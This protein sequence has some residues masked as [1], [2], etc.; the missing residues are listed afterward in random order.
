MSKPLKYEMLSSEDKLCKYE[1]INIKDEDL[2]NYVY[3]ARRPYYRMRGKNI[4][5]EQ[6]KEIIR[7]TDNYFRGHLQPRSS[8]FDAE[9]LKIFKIDNDMILYLLEGKDY[10]GCLNFDS[11][12][13]D[14]HHFSSFYGWCHP[15]GTIGTS[16]ITQKYPTMKELVEE[17]TEKARAFPFLDLT[18]A[19]TEDNE[20]VIPTKFVNH[21]VNDILVKYRKVILLN[22]TQAIEKYT[23]YCRL[24]DHEPLEE[25][26]FT[27][28]QLNVIE[29]VEQEY[30]KMC[31]YFFCAEEEDEMQEY[32]ELI[33]TKYQPGYYKERPLGLDYVKECYKKNVLSYTK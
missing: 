28:Q 3:A 32:K 22:K 26:F 8:S 12:W 25:S 19:M 10:I 4:T 21:I 13:F 18:I 5:F 24:Y 33:N 16:A 1:I 30:E 11:W 17:W 29:M 7:R 14:E 20:F 6:A 15:D 31:G 9:V 2:I 23:E 27:C